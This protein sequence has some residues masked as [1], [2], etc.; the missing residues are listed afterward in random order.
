M[1]TYH[2]EVDKR[3]SYN[4]ERYPT[5]LGLKDPHLLWG[6]GGGHNII[7]MLCRKERG[8]IPSHLMLFS[9]NNSRGLTQ[10]PNIYTTTTATN[11]Y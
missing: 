5:F 8:E 6:G 3:P 1:H 7:S 2:D 9:K 11:F 10:P 4:R